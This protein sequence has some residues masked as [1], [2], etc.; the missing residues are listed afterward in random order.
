[1]SSRIVSCAI[2]FGLVVSNPTILRAADNPSLDSRR[3][4]INQLL[5]DEWEYELKEA[6]SGRRSMATTA[7][8]TAGATRHLRTC[9]SKNETCRSGSQSLKR[10]IPPASPSR[11][12]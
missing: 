7:T 9:S 6:L 1:M 5:K 11:R 12:S 3:A 10:S 4:Q 8:T 2:L